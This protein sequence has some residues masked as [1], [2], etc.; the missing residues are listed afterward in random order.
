M[1][2]FHFDSDADSLSEVIATF[3]AADPFVAA[4]VARS[5]GGGG[6]TNV[7]TTT[8]T[9]GVV[10]S[11]AELKIDTTEDLTGMLVEPIDTHHAAFSEDVSLVDNKK[12]RNP[13]VTPSMKYRLYCL[14]TTLGD[15]SNLCLG[16]I[17]QG[18]TFCIKENC[19]TFH[20]GEKANV[21]M[22]DVHVMKTSETCF[23]EPSVNRSLLDDELFTTWMGERVLLDEWTKRFAILKNATETVS[24]AAFVELSSFATTA[25]KF[26]PTTPIPSLP[27]SKKLEL[28]LND[29]FTVRVYEQRIKDRDSFI[30]E[31]ENNRSK[32]LH[33]LLPIVSEMEST[34]EDVTTGLMATNNQVETVTH[35]VQNEIPIL[36]SR[37][38]NL[39]AVVGIRAPGTSPHYES[40][41]LWSSISLLSDILSETRKQV[42]QIHS[43]QWNLKTDA[44]TV[45]T[46]VAKELVSQEASSLDKRLT[47][48]RESVASHMKTLLTRMNR[49]TG[50]IVELQEKIKI[51]DSMHRTMGSSTVPVIDV[52]NKNN[53]FV[54]PELHSL[55]EQ[56]LK[57]ESSVR[58]LESQELKDAVKFARLGFRNLGE[59]QAW[60]EK[61][62]PG[63]FTFG[64]VV[65][66][67]MV[68][69]HV[70]V[71]L[72][73]ADSSQSTVTRLDA[74]RKLGVTSLNL[75][76]ALG[77]FD[78]QVPKIFAK[79]ESSPHSKHDESFFDQIPDYE[80][81]DLTDYGHRDKILN[82]LHM[83]ELAHKDAIHNYQAINKDS[84]L[85]NV[86]SKSLTDSIAWIKSF[87]LYI[88]NTY[89]ELTRNK[90]STKR[91][92]SLVT[93]LAMAI[94]KDVGGPRN[95]VNNL[96]NVGQNAKICTLMFYSVVRCHDI[97]ERYKGYN[98][99]S[100]PAIA[101]EYVRFLVMNTGLES[102]HA[103]EKKVA[104]FETT[105]SELKAAVKTLDTAVKTLD[106]KHSATAGSVGD[107]KGKVADL[108]KKLDKNHK[109]G[110][111]NNA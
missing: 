3:N 31:N 20:V 71:K 36:F 5:R 96:W 53:D 22:G 54:A 103:L 87:F 107:L 16:L 75:G 99:K 18:S 19:M 29:V 61:H 102:L 80:A 25:K 13:T 100:D 23:V 28:L 84:T 57:L 45:A 55:R 15:L 85:Y 37:Q 60:I 66:V 26:K 111:N 30:L 94:L 50:L 92:W 70:Y 27:D 11:G 51:I 93:R 47:S 86:A 76:N 14:P 109:G 21:F 32:V 81:W 35:R 106:T 4:T 8:G 12:R 1:S 10:S 62:Q 64:L 43:E 68:F 6:V 38:E 56:L 46:K 58:N 97:M 49:D 24:K 78:T 90:F 33:A 89:D 39:E 42:D 65:D 72:N 108:T 105:F 34:L 40:P 95:G 63:D 110:N 77:S 101:G 79:D 59:A 91:G 82:Q 88:D 67:H 83:F 17:G 44:T 41:T 52:P 98:F 48:L 104:T 73:S 7:P 2:S 74:L 69:E 9:V